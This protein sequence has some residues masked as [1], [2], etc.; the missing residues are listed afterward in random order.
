MSA[1][2]NPAVIAFDAYGTLFDVYSV[3]AKAEALF[4]GSGVALSRIWR[5]KQIEYSRLRSMA[6]SAHYKPFWQITEDALR[7]AGAAMGLSVRPEHLEALMGAYAH[8]RPFPEN[9]SV[10]ERLCQSGKRCCILSNG[11]PEMLASA[12]HSAGFDPFLE[13]VLSAEAVQCF[14]VDPRVYQLVLDRFEVE[15]GQV[16][17]VSSNGW[18]VCG[19]GWFGFQSFWVNRSGAPAEGLDAPIAGEGRD[20]HDLLSWLDL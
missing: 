9:R 4:P 3:G 16:V 12:V 8:L 18:D 13:A 20:L 5:E 2:P 19:A 17:F 15:A 10:L 7:H 6:G 14:K 1:P 11:S